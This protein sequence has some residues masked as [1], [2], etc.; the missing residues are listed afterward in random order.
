M[1][2]K[3]DQSNNIKKAK[4]SGSI[5]VIDADEEINT[6]VKSSL[7][8]I[9]YEVEGTHDVQNAID[10]LKTNKIDLIILGILMPKLKDLNM[11][12][13]LKGNKDTRYIPILVLSPVGEIEEKVAGFDFGADD[14]LIKPFHSADL[15]TQVKSLLRSKEE[16]KEEGHIRCSIDDLWGLLDSTIRQEVR[17]AFTT[18]YGDLIEFLGAM[19][20]VN[21]KE[22]EASLRNG[23]G[24]DVPWKYEP[25]PIQYQENLAHLRDLLSSLQQINSVTS[26]VESLQD[27]IKSMNLDI[28]SLRNQVLWTK[29]GMLEQFTSLLEDI[30]LFPSLKGIGQLFGDI[31]Q[32][33]IL[34][35]AIIESIG[36]EEFTDLHVQAY[37]RPSEEVVKESTASLKMLKQGDCCDLQCRMLNAQEIGELFTR[38][39]Q[40]EGLANS[41][42]WEVTFYSN[43]SARMMVRKSSREVVINTNASINSQEVY[44]L[45][46]HELTH[47]L[48]YEN[49]LPLTLKLLKVGTAKY[50]QT[51]EGLAEIMAQLMF[52]AQGSYTERVFTPDARVLAVDKA[53]HGDGPQDIYDMLCDYGIEPDTAANNVIRTFRGTNGKNGCNSRLHIYKSGIVDIRNYLRK[54]SDKPETY[55][56]NFWEFGE[57]DRKQFF[58]DSRELVHGKYSV[59]DLPMLN[60][61]IALDKLKPKLEL[62]TLYH[63][64]NHMWAKETHRCKTAN[65]TGLLYF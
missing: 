5:L 32:K 2:K 6:L 36:R 10:H 38:Y 4:G 8:A 46:T 9:G 50:L 37:G 41:G 34:Q 60:E 49:A 62:R 29:T 17:T 30:E 61:I 45:M 11:C 43:M 27:N 52:A 23:K 19:E 40:E 55:E 12:K 1:N 58:L 39:F 13:I 15:V 33:K 48:R 57:K 14:Y 64:L 31:L 20:P 42:D 54:K 53:L 21:Q 59:E 25:T 63:L 3:H 24:N 47:R 7:E 16:T 28:S 65:F 51:E 35:L 56:K 26:L 18:D 22:I 44:A